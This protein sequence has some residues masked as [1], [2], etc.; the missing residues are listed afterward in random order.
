VF[1]REG[2]LPTIPEAARLTRK[3]MDRKKK[4]TTGKRTAKT[5]R[6]RE[7]HQKEIRAR[8][9]VLGEFLP[10]GLAPRMRP[11]SGK[12]NVYGETSRGIKKEE[13]EEMVEK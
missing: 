6:G 3:S 8:P 7:K 5:S 2:I 13:G 10:Q 4:R 11:L 12:G 9:G 1:T